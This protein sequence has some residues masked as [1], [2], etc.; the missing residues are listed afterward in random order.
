MFV[1]E[2]EI[3]IHVSCAYFSSHTFSVK[4]Q[5]NRSSKHLNNIGDMALTSDDS[6]LLFFIAREN[7]NVKRL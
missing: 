5:I 6:L 2:Q 3:G 4:V 1:M 7:L